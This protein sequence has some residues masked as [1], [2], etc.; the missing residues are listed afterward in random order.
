MLRRHII[1]EATRASLQCEAVHAAMAPIM[2]GKDGL[3]SYNGFLERMKAI[4]QPLMEQAPDAA[5]VRAFDALAS[6]APSQPITAILN[7]PETARRIAA[8]QS[9]DQP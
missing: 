8:I 5:E 3:A 9:G 6:R 4:T 7:D 2:C 1:A